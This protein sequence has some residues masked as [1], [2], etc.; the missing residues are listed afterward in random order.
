MKNNNWIFTEFI[1]S[2]FL[3]FVVIYLT[4]GSSKNYK[5]SQKEP[6]IELTK[7]QFMT[8]WSYANAKGEYNG[9]I[10]LFDTEKRILQ[11]Q[12]DSTEIITEYKQFFK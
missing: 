10:N 8:I 6:V 1:F 11:R 5:N 12:K 9:I 3:I 7:D 2:L 4:I